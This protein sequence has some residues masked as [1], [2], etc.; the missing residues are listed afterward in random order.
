[1]KIRGFTLVEL[2]IVI[3]IAAILAALALPNYQ[4]SIR[5]GRRTDAQTK[6][7]EFAVLAER[8]YTQE[9]SYDAFVLPGNANT[10][11]YTF[12]LTVPVSTE[13]TIEAEPTTA[14]VADRCGTMDLTHAGQRTHTGAEADCW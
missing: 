2:M 6:L 4:E 5:K 10:A 3:A 11:F 9:N 12:T 13:Y 8:V 14:Q 1:M 7:L